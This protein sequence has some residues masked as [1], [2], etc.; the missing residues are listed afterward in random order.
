[1]MVF[2]KNTNS[3]CLFFLS[4]VFIQINEKQTLFFDNYFRPRENCFI[5]A[6]LHHN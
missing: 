6:K 1:M 5:L 4:Y 2:K 3:L